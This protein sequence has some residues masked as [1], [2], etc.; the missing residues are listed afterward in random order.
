M[1][2]LTL[3]VAAL[4]LTVAGCGTPHDR[5]DHVLD[6]NALS[7]LHQARAILEHRDDSREAMRDESAAISSIDRA[8]AEIRRVTPDTQTTT[9]DIAYDQ[10]GG[11]HRSMELLDSAEHDLRT[12]NREGS[13]SSGWRA[14][15]L[16]YVEDARSEVGHA[17]DDRRD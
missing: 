3:A 10:R 9:A 6:Q 8:M 4:A 1:P 15:A 12:A 2:K 7:D 5:S 11:L 14:E 16:R 13:S 17:I